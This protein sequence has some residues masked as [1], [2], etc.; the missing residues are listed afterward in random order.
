M[1]KRLNSRMQR[2]LAAAGVGGAA[3]F[4]APLLDSGCSGL[5]DVVIDLPPPPEMEPYTEEPGEAESAYEY[6]PWGWSPEQ[7][8]SGEWL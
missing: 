8:T 7:P 6:E 5:I 3:L 1:F 2:V 4:S